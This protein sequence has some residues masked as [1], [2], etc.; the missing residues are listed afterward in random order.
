MK[1]YILPVEERF[2]QKPKINPFS[3]H[4]PD[5]NCELD[6][7][8][9]MKDYPDRVFDP[10]EAD[11]HYL[12]FYWSYWQLNNDY[13]RAH[14]EE[15]KSYLD[16]L[17]IDRQKTFTVSEADHLPN[18]EFNFKVFSAN[19]PNPDWITIPELTLPHYIPETKPAKKY[20]A[21]FVGSFKTHPIRRTMNDLIGNNPE[22]YIERSE[23]P[24]AENLFVGKILESYASLCP[25]GSAMASY[26]F[27]ESMQLGVCPIMI[28]E[29]DMRPFRDRID[30]DAIS[31]WVQFVG[32]LPKVIESLNKNDLI[33]KGHLAQA[34]WKE[35]F[36]DY[37]WCKTAL[38]YLNG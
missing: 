24:T 8:S 13:G 4:S 38:N 20:L 35:L 23:H 34:M 18:S 37:G 11:W 26:R 33:V 14:R 3:H 19:T 31:Y 25:R 22:V 17:V 12:P 7:H 15:L 2:Y 27:Y 36:M 16:S 32:D 6:F 1:I 30:W 29:V 10:N 21:S 28:S 9:F 5:Y